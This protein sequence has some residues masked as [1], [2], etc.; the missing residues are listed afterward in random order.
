MSKK[1]Q[2]PAQEVAQEVVEDIKICID[3]DDA[4]HYLSL[5]DVIMIGD[6]KADPLKQHFVKLI[7]DASDDK[8]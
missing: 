5:I 6:S 8:K 4:K 3:I 7:N 2:E 1:A